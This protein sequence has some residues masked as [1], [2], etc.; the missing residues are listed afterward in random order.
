MKSNYLVTLKILG[1]SSLFHGLNTKMLEN[2][3]IFYEF[4][5]LVSI[6]KC[7]LKFI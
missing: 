6:K 5:N 2:S 7:F 4:E 1:L 3:K